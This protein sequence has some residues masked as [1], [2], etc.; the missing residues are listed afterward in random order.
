MAR[1]AGRRDDRRRPRAGRRPVPP[2]AAVPAR[3]GGGPARTARADRD[4]GARPPVRH[5]RAARAR[6]LVLR[7]L[8]GP[9]AGSRS[10]G[11]A[12]R[13]PHL[14]RGRRGA[15]PRRGRARRAR[16][17]RCAARRRNRMGDAAADGPSL[18]RRPPG[19]D[20][21]H[22]QPDPRRRAG[23]DRQGRHRRPGGRRDRPRP[24]RDRRRV[25]HRDRSGRRRPPRER[26]GL[27]REAGRHPCS[28]LLADDPQLQDRQPGQSLG[29]GNRH[30]LLQ[31]QASQPGDGLH[32]RR[33]P[34]GDRDPF[35]DGKDRPE[36]REPDDATRDLHDRDVHGRDPRQRGLGRPRGRDLL[37]RHVDV[38][39]R[40]QRRRRDPPRPGVRRCC[41]TRLRRA[42]ELPR[43]V[44]LGDNELATNPIPV[45]AVAD[46]H[47]V[48]K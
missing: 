48:D 41:A 8:L 19:A 24:G 16:P 37:Q 42:L 11:L 20:R 46:A 13:A 44:E 26:V 34:R 5:R 1:R 3:V 23:H 12:A 2:P 28:P 32:R 15:G 40:G 22:H 4:D 21:D 43:G 25:R 29:A 36:P 7:R 14:C 9:R 17:N 27:G 33:R 31:R 45:G 47:V 30:L 35:H 39:D 18:R 6:A 10:R 38:R